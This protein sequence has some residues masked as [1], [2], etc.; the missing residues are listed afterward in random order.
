MAMHVDRTSEL[1]FGL[2]F[3]AF[4]RL[5]LV[6][7]DGQRHIGVEPVRAFPL[8]DPDRWISICD[9][10][11]REIALIEDSSLLPD[12]MREPLEKELSLRA[13]LPR[14]ERIVRVTGTDPTQWEVQTDRGPSTFLVKSDDEIRRFGPQK[15]MLID[16]HGTRY[17]IEDVRALDHASRR[18]LE[19]YL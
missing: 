2:H 7:A 12:R 11:G 15:A 5:V 1:N 18:L 8:T 9:A 13:F 6:D 14:I 10:E 3:D 4:D 16:A 19:R 17:V